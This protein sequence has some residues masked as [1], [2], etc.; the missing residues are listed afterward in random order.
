MM[1]TAAVSEDPEWA[2]VENI[3][4]VA[5]HEAVAIKEMSWEHIRAQRAQ[6]AEDPIKEVAA[7]QYLE[8]W[9]IEHFG[10]TEGESLSQR[11]HIMMPLDLLS[12]EHSLYSITPFAK[13]GRLLDIIESKSRFSEP[14]ARYWMRQILTG[15][16][17]LKNAGVAHRDMSPEN[18][19]VD[20]G[21]VYIIDMGMCLRI[22]HSHGEALDETRQQRYHHRRYHQQRR[23]LILPQAPCGKWY[24]LSPEVCLSEQPFDG[25]AVDL[26]AAGVMLFIML[27]GAPPWEEPKMSDEN[28]KLMTTGHLVRI[29]TE[30]RAGLSVDAMDLLQRMLWLDPA[31]RLSLEQ[32][33]AHPWMTHVEYNLPSGE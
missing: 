12:D 18:L 28:F 6:L 33:C 22:P 15:L 30:R 26:W 13:N 20:D 8:R 29:L 16:S 23:S 19:M 9:V 32:V 11:H 17:C 1:P 2:S 4:W 10:S 3:E 7:M 27:T 21:E 24:Y 14:E 25:P 5:T 31:D